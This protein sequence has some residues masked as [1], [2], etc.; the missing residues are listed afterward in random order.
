M[1]S[2][3][4]WGL[5]VVMAIHGLIHLLGAA[6]GF[7]WAETTTPEEEVGTAGGVAW[8][9]AAGLV[10]AASAMLALRARPW[11]IVT[12][13]AAVVSEAVILTSWGPA[14]AG[15]AANLLL[16]I[17]AGYGYASQGPGSFRA[18]YRRR[19]RAALDQ[20][21]RPGPVTEDDLAHLPAPV[22]A[23]L[24]RCG[25]VGQPRVA[26][27]RA[28]IHGRI[29]GGPEKPWMPFTGE[30]FN[31]YGPHPIRLFHIEA[32]RFGLPAD[33]LHVFDRSATM[34]VRLGWVL[35]VLNAAG[36]EADRAET[37]TLLNDL[38]LLAPAALVDA[39]VSWE[40]LDGHRV[41]ATLTH[42]AHTVSA[43][44]VFNDD[45][46]LVDFIS[47]DRLRAAAD[48][49]SFT[50]QR[51][52]TPIHAYR[53][54]GPRRVAAAGEGR[55]HAPAPEGEFTYFEY[56]LD[57]VTYDIGVERPHGARPSGPYARTERAQASLRR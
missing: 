42:G 45:G 24:R 36:P 4:R 18:E 12:A 16:L 2:V 10:L 22:A 13:V 57:D 9:V 25:A 41:R 11:W 54:Y 52:S 31:T 27:T 17:A 50:R 33:V 30:Q 48:G 8:L 5:V 7:G 35:P 51:W 28:V 14:K 32:S 43:V 47:E 55:W 3:V 23:Y 6:M 40:Q 56:H 39:P 26:N 21:V 37:V 49:R 34:R 1:K 38:C 53:T 19:F 46:D 20:P 29:R 44:V 15:T